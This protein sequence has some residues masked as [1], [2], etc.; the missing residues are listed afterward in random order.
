MQT[1]TSRWTE[2]AT[3]ETIDNTIVSL[4]ANG[5]TALSVQTGEEAKRRILEMIPQ[6]AEVMTMT[7]ITLQEIGL[8]EA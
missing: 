7:S 2:L 8:A 3:Q 5:I 4:K 6:R 1:N